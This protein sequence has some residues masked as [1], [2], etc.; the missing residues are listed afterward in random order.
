[1]I[2]LQKKDLPPN[3]EKVATSLRQGTSHSTKGTPVR[4]GTQLAIRGV[5]VATIFFFLSRSF[6]SDRSFLKFLSWLLSREME[7]RSC[8][9]RTMM[10]NLTECERLTRHKSRGQR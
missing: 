1:M 8:T 10:G 3:G 7:Y 2:F 5:V 6:I 9:K 4:L